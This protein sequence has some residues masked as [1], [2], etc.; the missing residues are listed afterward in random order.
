VPLLVVLSAYNAPMAEAASDPQALEQAFF[1]NQFG[2]L[3]A[4][5]QAF[6]KTNKAA[7][8]GYVGRA[9]YKAGKWSAAREALAKA[10]TKDLEGI[11]ANA[12]FELYVGDVRVAKTL[13][14]K[15]RQLD[16]G[17]SHAAY[18]LGSCYLESTEYDKAYDLAQGAEGMGARE[19]AFQHSRVLTIL[20]GAQG[21]KAD[22]GSLMDKLRFGPKVRSTLERALS[23]APGNPNA[24]YA[25]GRYYLEAPG[26]IGGDP[27]K[28][29]AYLERAAALD[30]YFYK[31]NLWLITA[32][33]ATGRADRARQLAVTYRAKFAG[34]DA[35]MREGAAL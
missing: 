1:A 17:H 9:L 6:A 35:P 11:Y 13:Y 3:Q 5:A 29:I 24:Q 31:A 33:K 8:F 15:A 26:P 27:P 34:L 14:M 7:G 23:L 20:G 30:P 32:L 10:G 22:R 4:S 12:D 16:P 18:G 2:A 25:V 19:G 21:L 28:S